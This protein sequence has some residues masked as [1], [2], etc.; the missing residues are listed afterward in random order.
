LTADEARRPDL[1]AAAALV[2]V[3][4]CFGSFP[5]LGK[6]AMHEISPFVVAAFRAV[7]GA[8]LL[9]AL[10]RR[11]EPR[12]AAPDAADRRQLIFLSL[13]GVVANQLLFISGLSRTT[14]TNTALLQATMPVFALLIAAAAGVERPSPARI[15]GV[16]L[17]LSGALLLMNLS[18]VDFRS[19]TFSG[20]LMILVNGFFYSAYLV[21]ARG[22]LRRRAP[23]GVTA[24]LF[25]YGAAPILLVA[26]PDLLRF[27]PGEV[28]GAAWA[29]L[30][31]IVVFPTFLAYALNTWALAR[32]GPSTA[33]VFIYLQP[34]V[35]G[36]LGWS[37]LG[38]RPGPRTGAAAILIFA[39]I[40]L[41]TWPAVR[42]PD[43]RSGAGR[44]S[45]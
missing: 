28:S 24:A 8:V 14:V 4:F 40:A 2:A 6:I 26:L 38:E 39:G 31:A 43:A 22:I 23:I 29:A 25:R 21:A 12:Q 5:L 35:A 34:L 32:T 3:Q 1:A 17:A 15:L 10:A 11:V 30:A 45:R 37:V 16:P 41:A 18:G 7:F 19:R 9:T 36:A 13:L 27:R 33:A 42:Q 44:P 20:D